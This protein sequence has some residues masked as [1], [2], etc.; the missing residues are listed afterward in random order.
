[1]SILAFI[2]LG[3]GVAAVQTTP[4]EVQAATKEGW[5]QKNDVWYY[6][7]NGRKV[8]GEWIQYNDER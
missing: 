6:Y 5:V 2:L 4:V 1:M 8:K 7:Q 3:A